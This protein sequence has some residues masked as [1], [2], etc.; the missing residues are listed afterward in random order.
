M[1]A[2]IFF[3]QYSFL[4]DVI[5][6]LKHEKKIVFSYIFASQIDFSLV[7]LHNGFVVA[8]IPANEAE[9]YFKY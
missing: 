9:Q 5:E 4:Y 7:I 1:R 2:T 3:C 6:I 8:K